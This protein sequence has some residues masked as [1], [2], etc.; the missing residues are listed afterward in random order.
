VIE[1]VNGKE[2]RVRQIDERLVEE[3]LQTICTGGIDALRAPTILEYLSSLRATR[4]YLGRDG[5]KKL[6]FGNGLDRLAKA[7]CLRSPRGRPPIPREAE[8]QDRADYGV[9]L[10]IHAVLASE[11]GR[12]APK[13]GKL[14]SFALYELAF[15]RKQFEPFF[16]QQLGALRSSRGRRRIPVSHRAALVLLGL[17]RAR[18]GNAT[19]ITDDDLEQALSNIERLKQSLRRIS[20]RTRSGSVPPKT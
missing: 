15:T 14:G 16:S 6:G 12:R 19:P 11:V 3:A 17:T 20:A 7:V 10:R 9:Y 18:R 1:V 13:L 8:V 2:E 4:S 5:E